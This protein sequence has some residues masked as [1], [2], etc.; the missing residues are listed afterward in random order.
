MKKAKAKRTDEINPNYILPLSQKTP[1]AR[2]TNLPKTTKHN[3]V[4][5]SLNL[6]HLY[7]IPARIM[8]ALHPIIRIDKHPQRSRRDLKPHP[9][10]LRDVP[11][12]WPFVQL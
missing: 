10:L 6:H 7:L 1:A 11:G 9:I 2:T 12:Y 8:E 3:A 4:I 5:P